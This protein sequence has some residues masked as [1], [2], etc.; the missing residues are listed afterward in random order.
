MGFYLQRIAEVLDESY[1]VTLNIQ[2]RK[3]E[4]YV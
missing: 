2:K 4:E 1:V 3:G